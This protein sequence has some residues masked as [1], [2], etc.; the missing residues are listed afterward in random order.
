MPVQ[1]DRR[2]NDRDYSA[3]SSKTFNFWDLGCKRRK[4]LHNI[5]PPIM[6]SQEKKRKRDSERANTPHKRVAIGPPTAVKITHLPKDRDEVGAIVG[7]FM[8][9]PFDCHADWCKLRI[10]F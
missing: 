5:T 8:S 6:S 9:R 1:R 3:K 4:L 2:H 7:M 10:D